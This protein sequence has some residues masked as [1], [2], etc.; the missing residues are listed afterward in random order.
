MDNFSFD[1][2][3]FDV[4]WLTGG[5]RAGMARAFNASL[6]YQ[7]GSTG[8]SSSYDLRVNHPLKIGGT[9]LFLVGHGYAP[10]IT[11]RDGNGNIAYSGPTDLPAAGRELPVLRRGQGAGR[12]AGRHRARGPLLPDLLHDGRRRPGHADG[13]RQQPVALDARLRRR[14]QHGL[15]SVAVDLRARQVAGRPGDR[16]RQAVPARPEARGDG[17]AARRTRLGDL[18]AASSPGCGSRS[19]SRPASRSRSAASRSPCSGC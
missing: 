6:R 2:D 3:D 11:V 4:E 9:E 17:R 15:R 19:P 13:R 7:E 12:A 8:R 10:V 18:R 14:P 16:G 5:P 1:V